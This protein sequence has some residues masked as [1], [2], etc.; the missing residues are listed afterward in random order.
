MI[1]P[2][3]FDGAR[4]TNYTRRS[5]VSNV[6]SASPLYTPSRQ[7]HHGRATTFLLP[8]DGQV[9][10]GDKHRDLLARRRLLDDN[11][12]RQHH[13]SGTGADRPSSTL[14]AGSG[15]NTSC[16]QGAR[17]INEAALNPSAERRRSVGIVGIPVQ[18]HSA[19]LAMLGDKCGAVE[20]N[21]VHGED[22]SSLYVVLRNEESVSR[23]EL[24]QHVFPVRGQHF[25]VERCPA[26]YPTEREVAHWRSLRLRPTQ[27]SQQLSS[28]AAAVT[29]SNFALSSLATPYYIPSRK[30]GMEQPQSAKPSTLPDVVASKKSR[31][32]LLEQIPI[33]GDI[34]VPLLSW[35]SP[36]DDARSSVS[37]SAGE[38]SRKRARE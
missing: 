25:G 17:I 31:Y 20:R 23:A 29:S 2:S 38:S 10:A 30:E 4:H 1:D 21:Y 35:M 37:A 3:T 14:L 19:L 15:T 7:H 11:H 27:P 8:P 26:P 34:L 5:D 9:A 16:L 22:S 32:L 6:L 33:V 28:S 13:H 18:D 12:K 36:A 24:L